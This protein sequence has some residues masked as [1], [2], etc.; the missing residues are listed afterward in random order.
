MA[1][2][3][4]IRDHMNSVSSIA[5][6]TN[7]M[8]VVA[9]AQHQRLRGRAQ[10][11]SAYAEHSW[12]I[13][14][15]LAD[16]AHDELIA[17]PVFHA[18]ATRQAVALVLVSSDRGLAGDYDQVIVQ[19]AYR[20]MQQQAVPVR[21]YTI[22]SNGREAMARLGAEAVAD[23]RLSA[24]VQLAEV[25]PLAQELLDGYREGLVDQ[26]YIAYNQFLGGVRF[27]PTVRQLLPIQPEETARRQYIYEPDPQS[28][29]AELVPMVLRFQLFQAVL[30]AL[31]AETAA[32]MLAMRVATR[33][34]QDL[35]ER[36]RVNYNK[37]RQQAITNEM[38]DIVGG[39]AAVRQISDR[40]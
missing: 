30:E 27:S 25:A 32:R 5:K 7:A 31:T 22:G 6:V 24:N 33:N 16:A 28:L 8:Q 9:A 11:A 23:L 14:C 40:P 38:L 19:D 39:S 20:F 36:L 2:L 18:R 26:V 15:H 29:L 17:D 35:I 34:A 4:E 1:T 12:R 21:L 3:R 37:A 13:L 10:G